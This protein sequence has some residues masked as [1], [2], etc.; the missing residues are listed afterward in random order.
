MTL[1]ADGPLGA[2]VIAGGGPIL[3][4]TAV[5][6]ARRNLPIAV[7]GA[8]LDELRD[9]ESEFHRAG[10]EFLKLS[11]SG[12]EDESP[13]R[14]AETVVTQFGGIDILVTGA[15]REKQRERT[16]A[17]WAQAARIIE[18]RLGLVRALV[19]HLGSGRGGRIVNLVPSAGRYR[20]AYFRTNLRS[21]LVEAAAG[22]AM[23]ALTRQLAFELAPSQIWVNA[24][25]IG[26]IEGE[27][28]EPLWDDLSEK[29][30]SFLFEEISLGRFGSPDEVAAVIEFLALD[31]SS[32][33]TGTAVDVNGGWWMS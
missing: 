16:D 29:E 3:R 12:C 28:A 25:V 4:A 8:D 32:Y 9:L 7:C 18:K 27:T 13:D 6:L 17:T 1:S 26:L 33:L 30:R 11:S 5:R 15:I 19:P 24:V 23:L 2:A 14:F 10:H 20:T 31:G 22:G 21:N